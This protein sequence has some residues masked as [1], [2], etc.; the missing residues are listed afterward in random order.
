MRVAAK[1]ENE[2]PQRSFPVKLVGI[3]GLAAL[4]VASAALAG[5]R[6]AVRRGDAQAL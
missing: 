1:Q 6:R 3:V 2:T 5:W 4:A